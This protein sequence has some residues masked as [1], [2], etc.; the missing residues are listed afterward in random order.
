MHVANGR[1]ASCII[2]TKVPLFWFDMPF[3]PDTAA[4]STYTTCRLF[5]SP[6][7]HHILSV[8]HLA[9]LQLVDGILYYV[10]YHLFL[11]TLAFSIECQLA[12]FLLLVVA[13]CI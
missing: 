9:H 12:P 2:R 1:P 11:P 5:P 4:T 8:P 10:L 7:F 13:A 6:G 3:L